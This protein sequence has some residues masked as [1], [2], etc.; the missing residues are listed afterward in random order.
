MVKTVFGVFLAGLVLAACTPVG[1]PCGRGRCPSGACINTILTY[2]PF[3][4]QEVDWW[5]AVP[6]KGS[7][8]CPQELCLQSPV[9]WNKTICS[10]NQLELHYEYT[11][12][13]EVWAG[14]SK[15]PLKSYEILEAHV[16]GGTVQCT[17]GVKCRAGWYRAGDYLPTLKGVTTDG[18][19]VT[20]SVNG[21]PGELFPRTLNPSNMYKKEP[22]GPLLPTGQPV[23]VHLGGYEDPRP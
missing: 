9:D 22:L 19:M 12:G 3:Q 7:D 2:A 10:G 4:A 20:L 6:C 21:T 13:T 1:T 5:C 18:K 16:D 8:V 23:V 14:G 11:A 15:V 17:P